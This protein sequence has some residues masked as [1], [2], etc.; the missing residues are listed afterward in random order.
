MPDGKVPKFII[1]DVPDDM[2]E[3]V[4]DFMLKYFCRDEVICE[5]LKLVEDPV[6]MKDFQD[7]YRMLLND[8]IVLVAF[9]D[10]ENL[11]PG[12]RPKIAGCNMSAVSHRSEKNIC[13]SCKYL[14]FFL[15]YSKLSDEIITDNNQYQ[16]ANSNKK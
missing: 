9:L 12:Q 3:E 4:V 10:E 1:Q 13:R 7:I 15:V 6:S 2:Q 14:Q 16:S 8:H 5:C 11:E